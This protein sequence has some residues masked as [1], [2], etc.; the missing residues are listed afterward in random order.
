MT[1]SR[2]MAASMGYGNVAKSAA[3]LTTKRMTK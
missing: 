2:L 3:A 1:Q